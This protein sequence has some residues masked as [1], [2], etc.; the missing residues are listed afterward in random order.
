MSN[1]H[2]AG[3]PFS[4]RKVSGIDLELQMRGQG[5]TVLFLHPGD[6]IE[7][8]EPFLQQL[9]QSYRV[10]APSHPGFGVSSLPASVTTV[11]DLAYFYLD[12]LDDFDLR[13]VIVVGVSFGGW[14]AAEMAVKSTERIAALAL[15]GSVGAKFGDAYKREITDVFE[16][17]PYELGKFFFHSQQRW[18]LGYAGMSEDQL[19]RL[20][21]NRESFGLFGWS[22][23]LHSRKLNKRLHRIRVPTLLAWG[24]SDAIVKPDYGR[25]FSRAIPNSTFTLIPQAGHYAHI[26]QTS[27]V[28]AAIDRLVTARAH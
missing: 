19:L 17:P 20:A 2:A 4:M 12:L 6:G 24:E 1:V 22:P 5:R 18:D 14:I 9:S 25:E 7:S 16:I 27:T 13:D 21:R 8:S 28:V 3:S 10:F 11:D 15:I 26:D 23:T